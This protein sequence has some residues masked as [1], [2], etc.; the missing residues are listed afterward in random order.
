LI[1]ARRAIFDGALLRTMAEKRH[2]P[3]L[4]TCGGE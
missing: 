2:V 1:V 3:V 4:A